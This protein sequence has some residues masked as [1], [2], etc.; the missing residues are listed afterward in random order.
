M[1]PGTALYA[2]PG[3]LAD[4]R[5]TVDGCAGWRCQS[6]ALYNTGLADAIAVVVIATR[7]AKRALGMELE[8]AA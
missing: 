5:A 2:Y 4:G 6:A 7:A 3:S 8:R 1:L